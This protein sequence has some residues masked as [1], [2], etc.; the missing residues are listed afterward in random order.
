MGIIK[1][2]LA[3]PHIGVSINIGKT[4][5]TELEFW[6]MLQDMDKVEIAAYL[7]A[8]ASMISTF[9]LITAAQE[10]STRVIEEDEMYSYEGDE[11]EDDD[12]GSDPPPWNDREYNG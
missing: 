8:N 7:L 4:T 6:D 3:T 11:P 10:L 9:E 2:I 1:S 5:M 12:D